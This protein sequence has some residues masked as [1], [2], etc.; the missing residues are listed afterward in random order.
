M[1]VW[2]ALGQTEDHTSGSGEL[3]LSTLSHSELRARPAMPQNVYSKGLRVWKW[4][5]A[6]QAQ[7]FAMKRLRVT[8][9]ISLGEKRSVSI[10]QVD[11]SQF[12]IGSSPQSVQLLAVL[13]KQDEANYDSAIAKESA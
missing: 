7:Q 12:L 5:Q 4:L 11:G 6:K 10:V 9:T 3:K 1:T 13:G 2:N 8:E